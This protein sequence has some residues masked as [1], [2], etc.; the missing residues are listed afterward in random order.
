MPFAP[1]ISVSISGERSARS[2]ASRARFSLFDA[3]PIPISAVPESFM[4][5]RTSAKSRLIRPGIV[6]RSVIPWTP[7]RRTSSAMRN[8][9][10]IDVDLSSTSSSRSFGMTIVVSHDERS[11][12]TPASADA[13]RFVLRT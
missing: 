2:A 6:I 11:S 5:V 9:S 12:S 10:S 4:I 3:K 8:A 1:V 13:R 7:W